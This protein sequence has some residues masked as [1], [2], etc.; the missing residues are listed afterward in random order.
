M[1][2]WSNWWCHWTCTELDY[3]PL[4][5][6]TWLRLYNHRLRTS[7]L[8]THFPRFTDGILAST[9]IDR[10]QRNDWASRINTGPTMRTPSQWC[11]E[12]M[13]NYYV[14]RQS[15]SWALMKATNK[16]IRMNEPCEL[17]KIVGLCFDRWKPRNL[18][19]Y[20]ANTQSVHHVNV[21]ADNISSTKC[22]WSITSMYYWG[23]HWRMIPKIPE[24]GMAR[25]CITDPN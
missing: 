3:E 25:T 10:G 1:A 6:T 21:I 20:I 19:L 4:V 11:C 2:P 18:A 7:I 22:T 16:L 13:E 17:E 15:A 5:F 23:L 12:I 14:G 8:G 9:M 24:T